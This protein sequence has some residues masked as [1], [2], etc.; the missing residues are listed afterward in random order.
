MGDE[1]AS[2]DRMVPNQTAS[3]LGHAAGANATMR[4]LDVGNDTTGKSVI[5]RDPNTQCVRVC[6]Q[7]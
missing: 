7:L 4:T 6:V 1:P 5:F 3:V 2:F